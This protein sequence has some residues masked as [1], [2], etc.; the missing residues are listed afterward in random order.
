MLFLDGYWGDEIYFRDIED[1][2][3]KEFEFRFIFPMD[4]MNG[5]TQYNRL[6]S[7]SVHV[8][9]ADYQLPAHQRIFPTS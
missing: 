7:V 4:I 9:R 2:I 8:R 6:N 1:Q 3:R 5:I